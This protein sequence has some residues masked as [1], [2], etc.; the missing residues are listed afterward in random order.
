MSMINFMLI[1]AEHEFFYNLWDQ[2]YISKYL[3]ECLFYY[4]IFVNDKNLK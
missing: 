4:L 3:Y 1:W 2:V